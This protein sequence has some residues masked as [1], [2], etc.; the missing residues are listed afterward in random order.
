MSALTPSYATELKVVFLGPW[1]RLTLVAGVAALGLLGAW[2]AVSREL[3]RF[4]ADR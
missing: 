3:R 2:L 4:A 1:E